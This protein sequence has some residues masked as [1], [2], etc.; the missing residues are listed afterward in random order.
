MSVEKSKPTYN[1]YCTYFDKGY[2]TRGLALYESLIRHANISQLYILCLDTETFDILTRLRLDKV[3]LLRLEE[4]EDENLR[5]A[6]TNRS[7]V[8]YYWT[9]TPCL[10]LY[11]L[12]IYNEPLVVYVDSDLYFFSS[13]EPVLKSFNGNSI[14]I[15]PHDLPDEEKHREEKFGKYNVGFIIFRNDKSGRECLEW[16]R[17]RC[18][19]WCY[20]R[21]E[22]GLWGDQKYLD[23]FEEKFSGVFVYNDPALSLAGWNIKKYRN[24]LNRRNG[25]IFLEDTP[26]ICFHFSRFQLWEPSSL[27]LPDGPNKPFPYHLP[28]Y[29]RKMLYKPYGNAVRRALE[30]VQAIESPFKLGLTPRPSLRTQLREIAPSEIKSIVRKFYPHKKK[31]VVILEHNWGGR[32]ANQLWLFISTYAYCLEKGYQLENPAFFDNGSYFNVRLSKN[33]F[34]QIFYV[35]FLISKQI[36]PA[37]KKAKVIKKF[38]NLYR[39]YAKYIKRNHP[40]NVIIIPEGDPY[41]I[42]YLPPTRDSEEKLARF[43]NDDRRAIY[44][45]GWLFRNPIGLKK[46]HAQIAKYFKPK[47]VIDLFASQYISKLRAT[48]SHIVGVHI[49]QGDYVRHGGGIFYVSPE[50][51]AD[52]L[53]EYLSFFKKDPEKTC[54]VICSDGSIDEFLFQGLHISRSAG[55]LPVH[56]LYIL[57]KTD[58]ILGSDSTFGLFSAY[59][60]DI[61][62]IVFEKPGIDWEYYQNKTHYFENKKVVNVYHKDSYYQQL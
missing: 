33:I 21:E 9:L 22:P 44:F 13:L 27:I 50:K 40:E 4:I 29:E 49:R 42:N 39:H 14:L 58:I 45:S 15:T 25:V 11:I 7:I 5:K 24:Q 26:V 23:H 2:L 59:Y 62:F 60:G 61:P 3:T 20:Y 52:F 54:F 53:R 48:Y 46:Y 37:A 1:A 30:L 19:E 12:K 28:S 34:Y 8:E 56:D 41:N 51:V 55:I 10:P 57:A 18:I 31:K 32:L 38:Q 47:A 36:A 17:E 6:K 16:W 43:E 35:L